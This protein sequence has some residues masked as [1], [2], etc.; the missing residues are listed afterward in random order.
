MPLDYDTVRN[1]DFGAIRQRYGEAETILYALG[2]GFGAR[3]TAPEELRHVYEDGLE[4]F[5]TMATML[6]YPGFWPK[7]PGTGIDWVKVVHGEQRLWL[8]APLPATGTV[9]GRNRVIR[10][11]DKGRDKGA[12]V[13]TE[14]KLTDALDGTLLATLWHTAFCRGDG[15]FGAGDEAPPPLRKVPDS[16]PDSTR[17]IATVPQ[18][19]LIYRLSGDRNPLHA[20]PAVAQAAGFERPILH[21]LCTYGLAAR[22]V[23]EEFCGGDASRLVEFHVRFASPFFPGETLRCEFWRDGDNISY[24]ARS[25]ERDRVVLDSGF[26]RIGDRQGS[27]QGR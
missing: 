4:A 6:G 13:V 1:W 5:P 15:G 23:V 20:D 9:V 8:H 11:V 7:D 19:A 17:E 22:A 3:P 12:L 2:I 21:G 14:R 18:I 25:A 16:A 10:V 24:R 27:R 26:A